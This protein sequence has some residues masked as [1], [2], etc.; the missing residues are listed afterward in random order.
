MEVQQ[1]SSSS[2][3]IHDDGRKK[4]CWE[5]RRRRLV[6]DSTQP[7]CNRCR[8]ARIVCP[9]YEDHQPLR[10]LAPGKVTSRNRR[11]KGEGR[12]KS[13]ANANAGARKGIHEK[14][15]GQEKEEDLAEGLLL[16]VR[17][18]SKSQLVETIMRFELKCENFQAMKAVYNCKPTHPHPHPLT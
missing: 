16:E 12:A 3:P 14:K 15:E 8:Q 9:G 11:P 17:P 13:N 18:I 6:C 10:W 4:H 1:S 7:T 2:V 5:C